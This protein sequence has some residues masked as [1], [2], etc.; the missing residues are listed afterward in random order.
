MSE[1]HATPSTVRTSHGR[2]VWAEKLAA[3]ALNL[4]SVR[5]ASVR[6]HTSESPNPDS[7]GAGYPEESVN[8]S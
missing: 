4:R 6:V 1:F 3:D 8:E 7:I 5:T 2:R